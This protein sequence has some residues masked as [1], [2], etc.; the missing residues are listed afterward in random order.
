MAFMVTV[1]VMDMVMPMARVKV[2]VKGKGKGKGMA[3]AMATVEFP[4]SVCSNRLISH[5]RRLDRQNVSLTCIE[6]WEQGASM[7]EREAD[8][9][10]GR[11]LIGSGMALPAGSGG[12]EPQTEGST[13]GSHGHLGPAL[14][15][16]GLNGNVPDA[17]NADTWASD[18][19][20][21]AA[22][23]DSRLPNPGEDYAQAIGL[24]THGPTLQLP[25]KV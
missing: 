20:H 10:F 15:V 22:T 14:A 2:R 11:E 5:G 24:A 21:D 17:R 19:Q 23:G 18:L 9:N 7:A 16:V 1:M 25:G 6:D 13:H 12:D 3:M 4:K 8:M